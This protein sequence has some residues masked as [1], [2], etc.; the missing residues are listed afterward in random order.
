MLKGVRRAAR[1]YPR[2]SCLDTTK[3]GLCQGDL[4]MCVARARV[5]D[6]INSVG[7]F[8]EL[9]KSVEMRIR[10][11]HP[12]RK[13]KTKGRLVEHAE[14][15]YADAASRGG[16]RTL[17]TLTL[18]SGRT[19]KCAVTWMRACSPEPNNPKTLASSR[20]AHSSPCPGRARQR[21]ARWRQFLPTSAASFP[22]DRF[23]KP[24][25]W[26]LLLWIAYNG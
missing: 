18:V 13:L 6:N 5:A 24:E 8:S 2:S 7:Q 20:A 4:L 12:F 3:Q 19:A 16:V 26:A 17:Y 9:L 10:W 23:S 22:S 25:P 21:R 1:I 14:K 11:A 15:R